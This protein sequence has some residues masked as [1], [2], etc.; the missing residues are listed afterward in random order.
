MII[1]VKKVEEW[2]EL[3][4]G[5]SIYINVEFKNNDKSRVGEESREFG[6]GGKEVYSG[7]I[8]SRG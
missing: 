7:R 2:C 4:V 6:V 8:M 3:D 1:G 5:W